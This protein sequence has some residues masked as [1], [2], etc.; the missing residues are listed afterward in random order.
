MSRQSGEEVSQ[1][2]SQKEGGFALVLVILLLFAIGIAGAT[3]YEIVLGEATLALQDSESH[4]AFVIAR[5]GLE[6]FLGEEVGVFPDTV[7]YAL[8]GGDAVVIAR[9]VSDLNEFESMYLV[10]SEGIYSAPQSGSSPARRVIHQY[11]IHRETPLDYIAAFTQASGD[12]DVGQ[13]A[14]IS[15]VDISTT[16]D[17]PQGG[18]PSLVGVAMGSGDL[19]FDSNDL[20]G[21][22]DTAN[23]G[24][25][26]AVRDTLDIAWEILTD[27][28]FP[29]DFED[30]WAPVL[31]ADSFPVVRFNSDVDGVGATSGQGMLIVDGT[32]T[33]RSDFSW[34]G[35][36]FARVFD[37]RT[38]GGGA[39]ERF[40][41][42]GLVVGGLGNGNQDVDFTKH[43]DIRFHRCNVLA[44]ARSLS[45][46]RPI[47]R[48]WWEEL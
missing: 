14:I 39:A 32:F 1:K 40:R 5:S 13:E 21:W 38:S 48:S 6:R 42:R 25:Y 31:P 28:A 24:S 34:D 17:C 27:P 8:S 4:N 15:G 22:K 11:A 30:T 45:H 12:L 47:G 2:V 33:P 19:D 10:S 26:G 41:I 18:G 23:I 37:T 3:A 35:V 9:K 36:I 29:V 43:G 46:F 7:T 16:T 20:F 44:A